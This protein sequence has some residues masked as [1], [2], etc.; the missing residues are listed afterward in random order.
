[1]V[2]YELWGDERSARKAR[3]AVG[4]LILIAIAIGATA[5]AADA[6]RVVFVAGLAVAVAAWIAW[7]SRPLPEIA[8]VVVLALI[9][10]GGAAVVAAGGRGAV[11]ALAS[12]R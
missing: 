10:I 5:P 7:A 12:S 4:T 3:L 6:S 1:M 8:A 2:L 11:A 9:G